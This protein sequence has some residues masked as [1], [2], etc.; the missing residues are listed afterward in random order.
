MNLSRLQCF[1]VG[2]WYKMEI[3]IYVY[4]D[5]TKRRIIKIE[6]KSPKV[7]T[8]L[9]LSAVAKYQWISHWILFHIWFVQKYDKTWLPRYQVIDLYLNDNIS[10]RLWLGIK[11]VASRNLAPHPHPTPAPGQNGRQFGRRHFQSH[12]LEWKWMNFDQDFIEI[13]F[14]G[15]NWH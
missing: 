8:D 9:G 5:I 15:S 10:L 7:S 4:K 2:K 3:Y 12:F 13:C 11:K 1:R 14:Q 6:R